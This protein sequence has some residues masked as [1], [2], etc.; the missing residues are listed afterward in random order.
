[1][2]LTG[3]QP[4][5]EMLANRINWQ[6]VDDL[7]VKPLFFQENSG[8]IDFN[9]Y[10]VTLTNQMIRVFEFEFIPSTGFTQ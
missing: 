10:S 2:T 6:T 8:N 1:M 4:R 5:S 7:T 3:N 9:G